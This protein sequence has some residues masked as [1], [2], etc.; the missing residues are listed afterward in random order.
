[1]LCRLA[2]GGQFA[3]ERFDPAGP[4]RRVAA[5][6]DQADVASGALGEIGRQA[7]VFVAVFESGVHGAHEHAVLQGRETEVEWGEQVW[8]IRIDMDANLAQKAAESD[9]VISQLVR[10]SILSHITIEIIHHIE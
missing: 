6:D 7:V 8:V 10:R 9:V 2:A 5:R 4:V 3:G 1:M